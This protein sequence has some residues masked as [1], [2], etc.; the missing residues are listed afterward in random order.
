MI[1]ACHVSLTVK[2]GN[3]VAY[4]GNCIFEQPRQSPTKYFYPGENC[5]FA[6][7]FQPKTIGELSSI[8]TMR[9]KEAEPN[10]DQPL[11]LDISGITSFLAYE[12]PIFLSKPTISWNVDNTLP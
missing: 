9:R 12:Q 6:A 8:N 4:N 1:N 2:E 10:K 7:S 11:K 5:R 3:A